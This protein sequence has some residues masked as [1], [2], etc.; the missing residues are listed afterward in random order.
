LEDINFRLSNGQKVLSKS[1]NYF[2]IATYFVFELLNDIL[3]GG[4]H[5]REVHLNCGNFKNLDTNDLLLE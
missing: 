4:D 5:S 1:G 2:L 3:G